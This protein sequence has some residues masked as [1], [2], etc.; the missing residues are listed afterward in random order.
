MLKVPS[1][2]NLMKLAINFSDGII[3]GSSNPNPEVIKYAIKSGKPTL[4][5]QSE[6]E[7]IDQYAEFFDQILSKVV[8][9]AS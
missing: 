9:G 5:Y 4:P 6:E 8:D 2:L 3:F 7:Y 1:Y